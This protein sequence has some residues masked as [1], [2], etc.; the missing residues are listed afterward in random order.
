MATVL[1]PSL[2]EE[3]FA[4]AIDAFREA[5]GD[6]AVLT[7]D[8]ALREFRDPFAFPTWQDYTASAVVMPD[9]VEQIQAIVRI[10]NEHKVPLWTHATGMNNGYGGPAPRLTGSVIVSLRRMNR[11]LEILDRVDE[12]TQYV[13]LERL[14][15][16]PQCGFASGEIARTVTLEEQEAKLRLVGDAA[17]RIWA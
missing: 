7:G 2:S 10:A 11:V 6:D 16:S 13:P 3:S 15:I 4:L 8:D 17:R 5:V 1:T 9:T 14:A 12:A